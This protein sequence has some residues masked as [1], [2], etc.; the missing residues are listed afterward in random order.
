V[1][2]IARTDEPADELERGYA[3]LDAAAGR[4]TLGWIR[5]RFAAF[6][7]PGRLEYGAF[8]EEIE[9]CALIARR[10]LNRDAVKLLLD[11]AVVYTGPTNRSTDPLSRLE[12]A[13][14]RFH[15]ELA[16]TSDRL[17]LLIV[18][19]L[20][21]W[22]EARPQDPTAWR[23]YSRALKV[24]LTP[25]RR[26]AIGAPADPNQFILYEGLIGQDESDALQQHVWPRIR[27]R[28]EHAPTAAVK[29]AIEIATDWLR[30]GS[31][32]DI[33]FNGQR[34]PQP[35]IDT[36]LRVAALLIHDL[37][38]LAG[39]DPGLTALLLRTADLNGYDTGL[40]I[41]DAYAAFFAPFDRINNATSS[42]ELAEA[43]AR[44][45]DGWNRTDPHQVARKLAQ[46]KSS[47]LLAHVTWPDRVRIACEHLA[48]DSEHLADWIDAALDAGLFPSAQPF[49]DALMEQG[50]LLPTATFEKGLSDL[51]ARPCILSALLSK[52][53]DTQAML[54]IQRLTADDADRLEA[55]ALPGELPARRLLDVLTSASP[56]AR[57]RFALALFTMAAG[58]TSWPPAEIA[59]QWQAAVSGLELVSP[60]G[61]GDRSDIGRLFGYLAEYEPAIALD[62]TRTVLRHVVDTHAT[63]AHG[64]ITERL[65][66]LPPVHKTFLLT[67]PGY[68]G[69]RSLLVVWLVGPDAAWTAEMLKL[70]KL[71]PNDVLMART[72]FGRDELTIPQL[73][74]L[75]V[76]HGVDPAQIAEHAEFGLHWGDQSSRYESLTS[77]FTEYAA[78]GDPHIALVGLKGVELFTARSALARA[79]EQH[80]RVYGD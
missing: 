30:I 18:N 50:Q 35:Y 53:D 52:G 14:Q 49:I 76:P 70:G 62:F 63:R 46:I 75:L 56:Q 37:E 57:G 39:R 19:E 1:R 77:E 51:A 24:A 66:R 25:Y 80:E 72:G 41:D 36:A 27:T 71:N 31:G 2:R 34:P 13:V 43:V 69:I 6:E 32:H 3:M 8:E 9:T 47:L 67:D 61:Q 48:R 11:A 79:R 73:A 21:G 42:R 65:H 60:P 23:T 4:E 38:N 12:E 22:I 74:Q 17:R 45:V 68:G 7:D 55:L 78:S 59:A 26:T 15:P 20:D 28:L 33:P 58:A 29:A 64:A 54:A 16:S 40:T 5:E 44:T 10:Y